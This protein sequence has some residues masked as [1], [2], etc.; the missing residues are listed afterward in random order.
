MVLG[1]V[2]LGNSSLLAAEKAARAARELLQKEG[3][4]VV[5]YN[6]KTY[7]RFPH[8]SRRFDPVDLSDLASPWWYRAYIGIA[9]S[10]L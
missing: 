7:L 8:G 4:I 9:G 5:R 2:F 6:N 3:A 1:N 10:L